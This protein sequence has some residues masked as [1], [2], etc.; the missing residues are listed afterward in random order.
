M[1]YFV[2]FVK[3]VF[4]KNDY[5]KVIYQSALWHSNSASKIDLTR[6]KQY[7]Y[8]LLSKNTCLC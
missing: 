6:W 7:N 8:N 5:V 4:L 3:T 1:Y 2:V